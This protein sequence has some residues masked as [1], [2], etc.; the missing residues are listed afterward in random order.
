[1]LT[2]TVA[3]SLSGSAAW[4]IP[5]NGRFEQM[6]PREQLARSINWHKEEGKIPCGFSERAKFNQGRYRCGAVH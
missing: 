6:L 3:N 5:Q 2:F 1:M 4:F